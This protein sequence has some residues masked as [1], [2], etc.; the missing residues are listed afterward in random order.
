MSN[1]LALDVGSGVP[2]IDVGN[3]YA[4]AGQIQ[5]QDIANQR[6]AVQA[7]D[8]T[9]QSNSLAAYRAAAA[10]GDPNALNKLAVEIADYLDILGSRARLMGIIRDEL[11]TIYEQAWVVDARRCTAANPLRD[12]HRNH[13]RQSGACDR[14]EHENP[15][16]S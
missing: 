6:N 15:S 13:T 1:T 8:E 14:V 9:A 7:K 2:P 5:S 3:D 16:W 12:L 4:R 11:T 10:A